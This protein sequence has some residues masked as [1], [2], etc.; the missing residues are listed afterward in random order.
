MWP[1]VNSQPRC[2][3]FQCHMTAVDQSR[4]RSHHGIHEFA[5]WTPTRFKFSP[6]LI[7]FLV[8][9][10]DGPSV[11]VHELTTKDVSVAWVLSLD[12]QE[13]QLRSSVTFDLCLVNWTSRSFLPLWQKNAVNSSPSCDFR[14]PD[15]PENPDLLGDLA[16]VVFS[17]LRFGLAVIA[18]TCW[19]FSDDWRWI[20]WSWMLKEH[21]DV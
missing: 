12:V 17:G 7:F 21:S 5:T 16:R 13:G 3:T 19:N 8:R 4:S 14:T 2:Q 11:V 10:V 15:K 20:W 6:F 9:Y 1:V 18:T